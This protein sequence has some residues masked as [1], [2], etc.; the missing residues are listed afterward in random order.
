MAKRNIE[1]DEQ[2]YK[3]A[4]VKAAE[5]GKSLS[6]MV[7]GS[8]RAWLGLGPADPVPTIREDIYTVRSG[9]TLAQIARRVYGDAMKYVLIANYNGITNPSLIRVG[10]PLKVPFV[11][12]TSVGPGPVE[13]VEPVGGR[14]RFPLDKTETNYYKFGT[15]YASNSRWAGKPHPGVD[16]TD[17]KGVNV[18]A[19]GEGTVVVN[20][21]D[22]TGY[23][24]YIMIEHTLTNGNKI[25][26]LY[27][28][29]M[30]DDNTFRSP[31]VGTKLK[32][33]NIVIGRQGDTGYA[34]VTHLHFEIKKAPQLG[35]YSMINTQNLHDHFYDPY[36]FI[37][38]A[39]NR[40]QPV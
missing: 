12:G 13:P 40:Y 11:E 21:M 9:D 18:Y 30:E 20:K 39:D 17:R 26:S 38:N 14:F 32:G 33:E 31:P 22:P 23:G 5:E 29:L 3:R 28:H 34:G 35:L 19:I 6:S 37:R 36:S 27:G 7:E 15:L 10:Q 24:H 2:L 16:F 25:Y 1:V 4:L 8:L